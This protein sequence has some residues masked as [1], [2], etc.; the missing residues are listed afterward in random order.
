[1]ADQSHQGDGGEPLLSPRSSVLSYLWGRRQR[2]APS[3]WVAIAFA[4]IMIGAILLKNTQWKT[5]FASQQTTGWEFDLLI[6]A[7][8]A[9]LFLAGPGDIAIQPT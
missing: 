2:A 6:L 7:G 4:L 1:M 3:P 5:G 8:V 9:L